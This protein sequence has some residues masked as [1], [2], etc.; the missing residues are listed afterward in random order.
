V[1]LRY[2]RAVGQTLRAHPSLA[3]VANMVLAFFDPILEFG[4]KGGKLA[5]RDRIFND[6][7]T[8]MPEFVFLR[9]C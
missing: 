5:R 3:I 1:L 6:Q 8:I 9:L 4:T 7:N 2:G